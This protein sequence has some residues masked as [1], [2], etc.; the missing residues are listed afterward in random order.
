M[1]NRLATYIRHQLGRPQA[2]P[3]KTAVVH[4]QQP[5]ADKYG[6]HRFQELINKTSV[7]YNTEDDLALVFQVVVDWLVEV[8]QLDQSHIALLDK[9]NKLLEVVAEQGMGE[10]PFN[11]QTIPVHKSPV[12][13]SIPVHQSKVIWQ[14]VTNR[15]PLI[16]TN[17][18]G[19]KAA[20]L[21][22]NALYQPDIRTVM[23][24]PL[25][26]G[27]DTVGLV[28]C[29][30]ASERHFAAPEMKLA[31]TVANL[32]V[33]RIEQAR[34]FEA[35]RQR[36]LEAETLQSATV[37]LTF[38]VDQDQ[39]LNN[40]LYHLE[41]VVHLDSASI[42]LREED[43]LRLVASLHFDM[44]QV[45]YRR[46]FG[47][48]N[49]LF[50]EIQETR[51]PL[52]I[53]NVHED[54]RFVML[55]GFEYIHSWMG[56]PLL[57]QEKVIGFFGID[58]RKVGAYTW[59]HTRVAQA[60]ANQAA[61]TIVNARLFAQVQSQAD[62]LREA[63]ERLRRENME[64]QLLED[65]IQ[66]SLRR[67]TEQITISTEVAQ[68]I[69]AA[70]ALQLLFRQVVHLVKN[71]FDYYHAQVY[72]LEGEYLVLQEGSG[73][74]GQRL[75]ALGHRIPLRAEKGLVAMAAATGR[76]LLVTD[77]TTAEN[78]LPNRFLPETRSEIAVPIILKDE[79]LGVL[80]VQSNQVAGINEEDEILLLGLCGQIA[81]AINNRRLEDRRMQ[82]ERA[83]K[84]YTVELERS[85]QELEEF[86][87]VASHDLQEPLRKIQAFG[88]RL[89]QTY[90]AVLDERGLDYLSRMESAAAR[91]QR[92]I[93]DLL[94]FSRVTTRAQPFVEVDLAA[95]IR[96]V[97]LDLELEISEVNGRIHIDHLPIIEAEPTQMRQLL[98][99]LLSNALK[100][101]RE[102]VPPVVRVSGTCFD[103]AADDEIETAVNPPYCRIN[104]TD[105]GIGFDEKYAE[106]IFTVFQR[107][108]TRTE[109][110]GTG[111]GLALC[112]KIVERHQGTIT[113]TSVVEQGST[114][115]VTLPLKQGGSA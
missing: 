14:L 81:V 5:P 68:E 113:A 80:D 9:T 47:G 19:S 26:V 77:V 30:T 93:N 89:R 25:V 91:M 54:D 43:G 4:S 57:A 67:R 78:W 49:P 82:A 109:Y 71:R 52:V 6:D 55:P 73:E 83:L 75:K 99:N 16:V 95:V 28:S 90:G 108:H 76:P 60:F 35:E 66:Q 58:N 37:N 96:E 115:I 63:N 8:L 38:T 84:A 29:A 23:F 1:I 42:F 13:K 79:V 94:S 86:A 17:L 33:T 103:S 92:L 69:A 102:G 48:S 40:L 112:R 74:S 46:Q 45:D 36:R 2:Q 87:Y 21:G 18:T 111:L 12:H 101:H 11:H 107:L 24:I 110:K 20:E 88:S 85:N 22:L 64:R 27:A 70:P 44:S 34:L 114:F 98:Q 7:A 41:R 62:A 32:I 31:Q 104:I 59:H 3:G 39:I 65:Q 72:T 97:L 53:D 50:E 56:I 51:Q 10:R 100:F 61:A 15:A 106:R 105:N